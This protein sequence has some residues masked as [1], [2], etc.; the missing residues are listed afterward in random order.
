MSVNRVF[1]LQRL[2]GIAALILFTSVGF[3]QEEEGFSGR[4]GLGVLA[5]S[6][7]SEN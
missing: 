2:P 3:S 7:N 6:G 5:T 1:T 4:V